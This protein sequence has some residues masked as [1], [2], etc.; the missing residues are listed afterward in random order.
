MHAFD[1]QL[2]SYKDLLGMIEEF[3]LHSFKDNGCILWFVRVHVVE[4]LIDTVA[5]ENKFN[6]IFT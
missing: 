4:C 6:I 2:V 5:G 3:L 1:L